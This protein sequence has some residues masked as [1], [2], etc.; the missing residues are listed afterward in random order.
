[1]RAI[2]AEGSVKDVIILLHEGLEQ[3]AGNSLVNASF[4]LL[5]FSPA[6]SYQNARAIPVEMRVVDFGPLA[7]RF[8]DWATDGR[9]PDATAEIFAGG[10]DVRSIRAELRA[11]RAALVEQASADGLYLCPPE[12]LLDRSHARGGVFTRGDETEPVGAEM[13]GSHRSS[14]PDWVAD[15]K[16]R[17]CVP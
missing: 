1:M 7:Q 10:E 6:A 5:V 13:S 16:A 17:G 14:V 3:A 11:G 8:A 2:G 9:I 15:G 12:R 4:A